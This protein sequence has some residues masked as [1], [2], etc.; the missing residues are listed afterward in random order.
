MASLSLRLSWWQIA[1][2]QSRYMAEE[3][4]QPTAYQ[5]RKR[6]IPLIYQKPRKRNG[7]EAF[8]ADTDRLAIMRRTGPK[9]RR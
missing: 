9:S 5:L 6:A 2:R 1:I 3:P 4:A 7:Y 8:H